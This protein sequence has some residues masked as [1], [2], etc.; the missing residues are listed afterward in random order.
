MC[1]SED[2]ETKMSPAECASFLWVFTSGEVVG[3]VG[4]IFYP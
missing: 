4:C 3:V 1:E 2:K